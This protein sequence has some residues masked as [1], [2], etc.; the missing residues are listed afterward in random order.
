MKKIW[1][2]NH[3]ATDTYEN[4]SGRHFWFAKKLLEQGYIPSIFCANTF[5]CKKGSI[6][7]KNSKYMVKKSDGIT[8]IFVKTAESA[9]NGFSRLKNMFLFFINL[10]SAYKEYL[11]ISEKPDIIL[12]SSVHPL[13]LVAGIKISKKLKIPCICEV[14]DLWPEAIFAFGKANPQSLLGKL[15]VLGEHWIYKKADALIFTKEGDTDYIKEKGWDSN[16]GGDIDMLKCHYIN[17]GV[18][19]QSFRANCRVHILDDAELSNTEMFNVVYTG[20]LNPVNNVDNLLNAAKLLIMEKDIQ[21]IIYGYGSE[22]E[23]LRLKVKNENITNVYLKGF[24]E[25]KYI[26]YILSCSSVN[27]LNYTQSKY[28]WTR[29]NS[30]NKLFEYMASGKPVISTVKTGYSIIE[31]YHCGIS[32]TQNTPEELSRVILKI[33]NL[34][35]DEYQKMCDNAERGAEKFDFNKLIPK[36]TKVIDTLLR[37]HDEFKNITDI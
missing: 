30:S 2:M 6:D 24:V 7:L 19:I 16:S 22:L 33:K 5:L 1:I 23:A 9:G 37:E 8:Y 31:R 26:P 28:N 20:M 25:R 17:N 10:F 12:A 3:Y 11:K 4:K 36:L 35:P 27:I 29:G 18:D 13:T 32:L 21:F 34:D 14:R 15:L